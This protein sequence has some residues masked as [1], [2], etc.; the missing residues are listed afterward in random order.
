MI[1]TKSRHF[2]WIESCGKLLLDKRVDDGIWGALWCLPQIDIEPE[3]LGDHVKLQGSFK[4]TF[5]HYK[6]DGKVWIINDSYT[7][8]TPRQWIPFDNLNDLGLPKPIRKL[9]EKHLNKI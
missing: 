8:I 6:L 1:P 7:E 4:H 3:L 9:I 5:S 2:L